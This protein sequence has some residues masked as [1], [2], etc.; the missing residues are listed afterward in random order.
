[1]PKFR[2]R[3]LS[4]RDSPRISVIPFVVRDHGE[5]M[6]TK[7]QPTWGSLF[8][9][10]FI[11]ALSPAFAQKPGSSAVTPTDTGSLVGTVVDHHGVPVGGATITV[12]NMAT[13]QTRSGNTD[14]LGSFNF[15]SLAP[16]EY[17]VTA[18]ARGL[19]SRTQRVH[20]KDRHR[21]SLHFKLKLSLGEN[22]A[23]T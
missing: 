10:I 13:H 9:L 20:I 5:S 23:P 16:G 22:G 11:V 7:L 3:G 4:P 6:T 21:S 12:L 8:V 14:G 2:S 18:S 19:V 1:M 17:Q 15:D